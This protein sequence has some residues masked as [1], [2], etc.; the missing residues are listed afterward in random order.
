MRLLK[1]QH[2]ARLIHTH[3]HTLMHAPTCALTHASVWAGARSSA[4][5]YHW[6][7]RLYSNA[8]LGLQ[9]HHLLACAICKFALDPPHD[10]DYKPLAVVHTPSW[11]A[12][13]GVCLY[14][15]WCDSR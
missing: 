14:S 9:S 2:I 7:W 11:G 6:I 4:A 12:V 8:F 5:R 10:E 15:V 1:I 3:S 13:I